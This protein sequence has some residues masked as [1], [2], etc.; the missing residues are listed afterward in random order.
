M[1]LQVKTTFD[2]GKL[3]KNIDTILKGTSFIIAR[4]FAKQTEQNI[5]AGIDNR[6]IPLDENTTFTKNRKGHDKPVMIDKGWL[7]QSIKANKDRLTM[8][9]YGWWN[10]TGTESGHKKRPKRPFIGFAQDH[11][12]YVQHSQNLMRSISKQISKALKK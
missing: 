5:D 9:E 1:K 11:P 2:F 8:N 6:G 7:Y 4:Q 10:H 12:N 3:A